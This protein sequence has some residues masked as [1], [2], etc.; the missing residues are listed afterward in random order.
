M[1]L[2]DVPSERT[3]QWKNLTKRYKTKAIEWAAADG[4]T[5]ALARRKAEAKRS[6]QRRA[7]ADSDDMSD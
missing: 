7:D 6:Q 2:S 3:L 5:S 4:D 1:E